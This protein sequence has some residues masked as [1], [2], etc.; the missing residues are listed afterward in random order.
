MII[1][2]PT[3][4]FEEMILA[5]KYGHDVMYQKCVVGLAAG[6]KKLKSELAKAQRS[7]LE[8]ST[9]DEDD[10]FLPGVERDGVEHE[11]IEI[12]WLPGLAPF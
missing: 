8:N 10:W 4:A 5:A 9:G 7:A 2:I 3:D 11:E 6:I 12:G 1:H